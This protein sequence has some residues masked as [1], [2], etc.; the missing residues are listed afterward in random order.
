MAHKKYT[1]RHKKELYYIFLIVVVG[2]ILLLSVF[3]PDGYLEMK[4]AQQELQLQQSQVDALKKSNAESIK[5]IE[6]LR[7][8]RD[9]IERY[10]REDGYGRENEI[11]EQLPEDSEPEP[12]P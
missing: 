3:G 11:I 5:T 10:A 2:G 8:D 1:L 12:S 7:S 4:K 9:A 6:T